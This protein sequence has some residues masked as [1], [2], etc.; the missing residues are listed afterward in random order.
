LPSPSE[1]SEG[2]S[3]LHQRNGTVEIN[4]TG[5]ALT[6]QQ[7][8]KRQIRFNQ[9]FL[10]QTDQ[11]IAIHAAMDSE[12]QAEGKGVSIYLLSL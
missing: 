6:L 11:I 9:L 2:N 3:L 1:I 12:N 7:S 4:G 8:L 5:T 10:A